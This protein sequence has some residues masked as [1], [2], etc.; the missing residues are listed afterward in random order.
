MIEKLK[1]ILS[2]P[3]YT[4]CEDA[5]IEFL[6][7]EL[8]IHG[9]QYV[10]DPLGN[11]FVTKGSANYYPCVVSH[12]DTVHSDLTPYLVKE[13][14]FKNEDNEEKIGLYGEYQNGDPAGIG[15]DDKC[16]IFICL[17][18]LHKTDNI[19]V[20]FFVSEEVG[21][22]GSRNCDKV[23][24]EDIGYAIQFDA[25]G[26]YGMSYTCMGY[27]L[28]DKEG[29]FMNKAKPIL[30]QHIPKYTENHHP[31]TDV[32]ILKQR[33][34]FSC[35]NI[36]CGYYQYHTK[37]EYVIIDD[38]I[39]SYHLGNDLIKELGHRRYQVLYE[40]RDYDSKYANMVI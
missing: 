8:D 15:G 24:F 27:P 31:Y 2:I 12:T 5:M 39:N 6:K 35:F 7:S 9:Y 4:G 3:S 17:E 36:P 20:A 16:G 26:K 28:Y 38:V 29:E 33:F 11:I 10:V 18:L 34:G 30:E 14:T 37:N 13:K 19:K 40:G 32:Y 22:L 21:C 23:F 25:P 1:E